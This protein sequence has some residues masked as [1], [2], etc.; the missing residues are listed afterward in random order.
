MTSATVECWH[1]GGAGDVAGGV[2]RVIERFCA[3]PFAAVRCV[4]LPS[5]RRGSPVGTAVASLRVLA[6]ILRARR[7]EDVVLAAHLS[8]GG[9]F[10]REGVLAAVGHALGHPVV[11][12]L[13]GS[14]FA[15]FA[16]RRPRLV[17]A[18]L[19]RSD[20]VLVL[21]DETGE[22]VRA[23][24]PAVPVVSQP[25]AVDLRPA[26]EKQPTVVFAGTVC[27]RKGVDVLLDAWHRRPEHHGFRLVLLGPVEMD[28]SPWHPRPDVEVVG[29]VP[30]GEVLSRMDTAS[31]V[32]LPSRAEAMPL[33]LLEAM[34]A[35]CAV[36]GTSV[37]GVTHLLRDGAGV[38]VAPGDTEAFAEMLWTLLSD[39]EAIEDVSARARA[40]IDRDHASTTVFPAVE[41]VW[42]EAVRARGSGRV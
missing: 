1:L 14:S 28:L 18:V 41:Q 17:R 29:P 16:R 36:I 31:V 4:A 10:L 40:R 32:V 12:H 20:A 42:L 27:R 35:G 7:R 33:A 26:T 39:S 19:S 37:G 21:S 38:V 6:R 11:I 9:S 3:F 23:A 24:V 30:H 2:S 25:N 5:R 22:A 34:A 8:Q 13:H 15:A